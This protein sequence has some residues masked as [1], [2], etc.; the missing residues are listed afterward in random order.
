LLYKGQNLDFK[1]QRPKSVLSLEIYRL[2]EDTSST[3]IHALI[4]PNPFLFMKKVLL[5][6]HLLKILIY[7]IFCVVSGNYFP[8]DIRNLQYYKN[9]KYQKCAEKA[10]SNA[11]SKD[12]NLYLKLNPL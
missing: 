6:Q 2:I 3:E 7:N 10:L 11:N 9:L 4:I 12:L 5:T 1:A 8:K